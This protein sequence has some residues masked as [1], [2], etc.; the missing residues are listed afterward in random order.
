MIIIKAYEAMSAATESQKW[1]DHRLVA[2][3]DNNNLMT[4]L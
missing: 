4:A 2:I 3:T 1:W